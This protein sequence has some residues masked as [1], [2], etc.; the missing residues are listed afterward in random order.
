MAP[1]AFCKYLRDATA[2]ES[3]S[4]NES[5]LDSFGPILTV[6]T[7]QNPQ[8]FSSCFWLLP[9]PSE[10]NATGHLSD[11]KQLS[12]NYRAN[13]SSSE[14]HQL[15]SISVAGDC[16]GNLSG[17]GQPVQRQLQWTCSGSA[18]NELPQPPRKS[19]CEHHSRIEAAPLSAR[20]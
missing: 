13:R 1:F 14:L 4:H 18:A 15:W 6:W 3:A 7:E 16:C 8:A 17:F 20:G 12:R 11:G 10:P 9:H 2:G 19:A 5:A